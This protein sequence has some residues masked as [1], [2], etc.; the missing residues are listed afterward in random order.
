LLGAPSGC[1]LGG[2]SSA[3]S[4]ETS[5][6][7]TTFSFASKFVYLFGRIW[8]PNVSSTSIPTSFTAPR[9]SISIFS[10]TS[11]A[12]FACVAKVDMV[13]VPKLLVESLA[14]P[15]VAS[16]SIMLYPKDI[17]LFIF[18]M[19]CESFFQHFG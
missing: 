8:L 13:A 15:Y 3:L 5:R 18:S 11:W 16:I 19:A 2:E 6:S 12:S 17:E 4:T 7:S 10:S 9:E 14:L 1:D